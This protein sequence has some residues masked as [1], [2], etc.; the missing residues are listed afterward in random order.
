MSAESFEQGIL[1]EK[2][3]KKEQKGFKQQIKEML[4]VADG[5]VT[6]ILSKLGFIEED[7]RRNNDLTTENSQKLDSL[8]KEAQQAWQDLRQETLD[9]EITWEEAQPNTESTL[10]LDTLQFDTLEEQLHSPT[11]EMRALLQKNLGE[12]ITKKLLTSPEYRS[13]LKQL[14]QELSQKI[15]GT[16]PELCTERSLTNVIAIHET[17]GNNAAQFVR[18]FDLTPYANNI[19]YQDTQGKG[20]IQILHTDLHPKSGR[21]QTA[22]DLQIPFQDESSHQ[23]MVQRQFSLTENINAKGELI[24]KR[25]V[26]HARL[27]LPT[28]LKSKNIAAQITKKSL[29]LYD[30]SNIDEIGLHA[31]EVGG[32]A[33]ASYGYGWD[34]DKMVELKYRNQLNVQ[35]LKNLEQEVKAAHPEASPTDLQTLIQDE[36]NKR[37]Q[38]T[39]TRTE[40][41]APFL[42]SETR[43][44]L[45]EQSLKEHIEDARQSIEQVLS[46]LD[47]LD[48]QGEATQA[49]LKEIINALRIAEENPLA[50]TPQFI[51]SLGKQGP[52]FRRGASDQWYTE[53]QFQKALADGTETGEAENYQGPLHLGKVALLFHEWHGKIELKPDGKQQGKNRQLIEQKI[54]RST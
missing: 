43:A 24:Q 6:R 2:P 14:A 8:K 28:H 48:D 21:L 22:I 46:Q 29:E 38:A 31:V 12:Q 40:Q 25:R 26:T 49:E 17:L 34:E 5:H 7:L 15:G 45:I 27:D 39:K 1:P 20:L 36:R 23:T 41:E 9:V 47:L 16:G 44:A 52:F 37:L 54:E 42:S 35:A 10:S 30:Q 32:Y 50:V 53:D 13:N 11:E 19:Q 3:E 51:A 33:W 4:R 18:A